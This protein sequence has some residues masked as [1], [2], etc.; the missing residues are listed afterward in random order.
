MMIY[1]LRHGIAEN[2]GPK[3]PDADRELTGEGRKKLESVLKVAKRAGA[4]PDLAISSPLV[5]AVQTAEIARQMLGV[6]P[7]VQKIDALAPHGS[8]EE[9]WHEV[10]GLRNL[11]EVLLAGHE[12]SMSHLAAWILGAP[13]LQVD[14]KKAALVSIEIGQ[15]RGQ[16]HGILKW[17]LTPKLAE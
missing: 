16:P 6:E 9:V 14:M 15:F 17:M 10:S 2:A 5:R 3:T 12:P 8:P 7:P 4:K 13:S 1:L 11:E